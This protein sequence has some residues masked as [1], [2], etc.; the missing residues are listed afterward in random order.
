[1]IFG[2]LFHL[3]IGL[4]AVGITHAAKKVCPT[5]KHIVCVCGVLMVAEAVVTYSLVG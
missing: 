2:I 1:M 3:T 5:E 4:L